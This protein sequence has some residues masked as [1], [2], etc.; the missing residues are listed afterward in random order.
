MVLEGHAD[1]THLPPSQQDWVIAPQ[2]YSA[3]YCAGEC[4]YPLGHRM[5][6]T[7]HATMQAMVSIT[8]TLGPKGLNR[9]WGGKNSGKG[10]FLC[11]LRHEIWFLALSK[12]CSHWCFWT[13][14]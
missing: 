13:D 10:N 12:C 11:N 3:Y 5:N 4:N 9:L 7:N 2:G 1:L 6:S 8:V 14:T